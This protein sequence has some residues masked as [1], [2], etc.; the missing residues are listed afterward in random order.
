MEREIPRKE[1]WRWS[2]GGETGGGDVR[3]VERWMR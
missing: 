1:G 3:D 2:E